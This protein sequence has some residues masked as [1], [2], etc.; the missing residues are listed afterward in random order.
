MKPEA[1]ELALAILT[2]LQ[3]KGS[4]ANKTKLLKL[5]YL[6]DIEHFRKHEE[7]ITGF[8]WRFHLYGPW[9]TEYDELID[10]LER[11]DY[12]S[13]QSWNRDGLSGSRIVLS[14]RRELD[15]VVKD[16]DEFFRIQRLIDTWA[17]RSLP[18]L[19]THVYFET[20]PMADAVSQQPLHFSQVS[21][22]PP[23]L[24]RRSTSS[25]PPKTIE[26]LKSRLRAYQQKAEEQ[27]AR[28]LESFRPPVYDD[29]YLLAL[30]E[31]EVEKTR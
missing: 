17:D 16:A 15:T 3:E 31:L 12:V 29:V 13:L 18:D 9:A 27:R 20:E 1:G 11:H 2:R 7:T 23:V 30:A 25:T 6:A 19:L 28:A 26:R 21:K 14:E 10:D 8:D 24:Y 5:L 22:T 4:G